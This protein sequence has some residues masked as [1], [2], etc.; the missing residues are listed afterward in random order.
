MAIY[1]CN[2][3]YF[4]SYLDKLGIKEMNTYINQLLTVLNIFQELCFFYDNSV[5]SAHHSRF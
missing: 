3:N 5:K 4:T 2:N 1:D